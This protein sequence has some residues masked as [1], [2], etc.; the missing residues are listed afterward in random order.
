MPAFLRAFA[1]KA[2]FAN[3]PQDQHNLTSRRLDTRS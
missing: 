3:A 1:L 2:H